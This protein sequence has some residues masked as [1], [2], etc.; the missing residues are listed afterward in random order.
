MKRSI[1]Y[2]L[3]SAVLLL[4]AATSSVSA[5][6]AGRPIN[7]NDFRDVAQS[8]WFYAPV[9]FGMEIGLF[10]GTGPTSFSPNAPVT[11]AMFVTILGRFHEKTVADNFGD[12]KYETP[13]FTDVKDSDY[14]AKVLPWAVE[15]GLIQGIGNHMFGPNQAITREDMATILYRYAEYVKLDI[16][17]SEKS[18]LT[19]SDT[20]SVS[21]YAETPLK[22]CTDK[23]LINGYKNL[24]EPKAITNRGQCAQ[25]FYNLSTMF[26]VERALQSLF[27][28]ED[29]SKIEL[30]DG[31]TGETVT[32][33]DWETIKNIRQVLGGFRY[34]ATEIIQ[35]DGWRYAIAI[36]PYADGGGVPQVIILGNGSLTLNAITYYTKNANYFDPLFQMFNPS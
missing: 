11:R 36:Y 22:W 30:R 1:L 31:N 6:D 17:Y 13:S 26:D 20:A 2:S 14:Y 24:L 19:F 32:I 10:N 23:N 5:L 8:D 12:E 16:T 35:A 18:Y 4:F 7:I 21:N 25:V 3:V 34:N 9:S 33:T 28:T 29:I 27:Q 15:C